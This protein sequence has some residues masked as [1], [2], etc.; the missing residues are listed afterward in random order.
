MITIIV[1]AYNEEKGLPIV[2]TQ[3]LK[4]VNDGY[5]ILVIDDGSK[6]GTSEAA[7][8]FPV[9]LIK[10][11]IN[12]G[13][14]E[15]LK[16]GLAHA[17][18]EKIILIDSDGSYPADFVPKI[19]ESL[20]SNDLVFCS[21]KYGMENIPR[22]NR[23]GNYVFRNM[24]KLV[25]GFKPYDPFSG[26]YGVKAKYLKMM[27]ISSPRFS[28]EAEIAAKAGRM[29]LKMLDL[30]IKY[31]SRIGETKLNPLKDGLTILSAI[32]SLFF[33]RPSKDKDGK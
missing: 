1:P 10:H 15:A 12:K 25:Y 6:D 33:W 22:F 32:L 7:K 11:E 5:E 19:A 14:G 3:L 2:L 24:I 4:I 27:N 26:L 8:K 16:T 30:P 17:R 20:D 9:T 18:G 31:Q 21:R 13:K 28:V 29:K 23:L